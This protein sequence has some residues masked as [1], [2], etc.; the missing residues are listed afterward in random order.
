MSSQSDLDTRTPFRSRSETTPLNTTAPTSQTGTPDLTLFQRAVYDLVRS[1]HRDRAVTRHKVVSRLRASRD[2]MAYIN[3]LIDQCV[4]KGGADGLDI[5]ID[6]LSQFGDLVLR[7]AREFWKK[8]VSRWD[9]GNVGRRHHFNDD[10]WYILLRSAAR[11]RLE[12]SQKTQMLRYCSTE[13]PPSV[14]EA[15]V[16]A[17]GDMGGTFAAQFLHDLKNSEQSESVREVVVEV[18]DDLED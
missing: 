18:L 8:D 12:Q 10:A 13:G 15:G 11:S 5:G 7:Y 6:V 17:F 16:H 4:T 2:P 1:S 9:E 14:R 3:E